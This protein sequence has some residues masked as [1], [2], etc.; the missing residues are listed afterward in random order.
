MERES[1]RPKKATKT[2]KRSLRSL[3]SIGISS[4]TNLSKFRV[5]YFRTL[6]NSTQVSQ[7]RCSHGPHLQRRS[8][9]RLPTNP[10][11]LLAII[12]KTL[13][14]RP[15][16]QP[17]LRKL[18]HSGYPRRPS[19]RQLGNGSRKAYSHLHQRRRRRYPGRPHHMLPHSSRTTSIPTL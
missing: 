1:L 11:N 10:R 7:E 18:G 6:A 5:S 3:V 17:Y 13:E 14:T 15:A 19:L 8:I 9:L 4:M 2:T 12:F 16:G